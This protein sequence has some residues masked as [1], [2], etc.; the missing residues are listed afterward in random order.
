MSQREITGEDVDALLELLSLFEKP[1]RTFAKRAGASAKV[2]NCIS[3]LS[4]SK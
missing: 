3:E 1:G 2:P 4:S